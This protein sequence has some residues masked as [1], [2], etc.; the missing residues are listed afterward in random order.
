MKPFLARGDSRNVNSQKA[1]GC[2]TANAAVPGVGSLAGGRWVGYFQLALA[3]VGTVLTTVFGARFIY[4]AI[5]NMARLRETELFDPAANLI[6]LYLQCRW[7]VVG[8]G[9]FALAWLWALSTSLAILRQAHREQQS[10]QAP[11]IL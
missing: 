5:G 2:L 6:E 8:I 3:L 10:R 11:P 9:V 7:A 4:W 1:W